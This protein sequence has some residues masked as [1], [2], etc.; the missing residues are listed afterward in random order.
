[1]QRLCTIGVHVFHTSCVSS[2]VHMWCNPIL[3]GSL[4]VKKKIF[5]EK[6]KNNGPQTH[7]LSNYYCNYCCS[8]RGG[9]KCLQKGKAHTVWRERPHLQVFCTIPELT[10]KTAAD[11]MSQCIY[12]L[13]SSFRYSSNPTPDFLHLGNWI[14]MPFGTKLTAVLSASTPPDQKISPNRVLLSVIGTV[15]TIDWKYKFYSI[16]RSATH[17]HSEGPARLLDILEEKEK[18]LSPLG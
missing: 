7:A 11:R 12:S 2:T 8:L 9:A 3:Q 17:Q 18:Y 6:D 5:F 14:T 15:K 10:F 13:F 16:Y 4:M 1:M